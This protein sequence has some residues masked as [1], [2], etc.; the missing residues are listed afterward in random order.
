MIRN[1]FLLHILLMITANAES[2][3]VRGNAYSTSGR[4]VK[5]NSGFI[6]E[7]SD[8][9]LSIFFHADR[10]ADLDLALKVRVPSGESTLQATVAGKVWSASLHGVTSFA[11]AGVRV[12]A[13]GYVRVD[14][15][16]M[17]NAGAVIAEVTELVVTS[18][19]PGLTL[20][21][22]KD[23]E[24]NRFYWGRR[25]PSVHLSYAPPE[26][27]T[28]EWFYNEVTVPVGMDPVGSYFMANGFG[29]GYFGMQVNSATERR[30]LF[31]VWSPFHTDDPKNIPEDKR[32]V[33]LAKG[34]GVTIGEFGNEGSGGQS[35]FRHSW[36]AGE[37]YRFLNQA[38]PDGKGGTAYSAW[39]FVKE[40]AR[41]QLIAS[42]CRP[43]TDKHL[44]GLHSF[45]ENFMDEQGWITREASYGNQW[46]RDT[47]GQWH[48]LTT[49]RFTAD[50]IASRG[51]RLD[52][53][54]GVKEG[55]FFLRNGGFFFEP[56]KIGSKFSLDTVPQ[57]PPDIDLLQIESMLKTS[58]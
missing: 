22:V 33:M 31:S 50:D 47:D 3:P 18:A 42:F 57:A 54:G 24:A 27:K 35:F 51:Y 5:T 4:A 41:W 34:D 53:T 28:I 55:R 26:G 6:L 40:E 36:K 58:H 15:Q 37:T 25:G 17:H 20:S 38:R 2:I 46:A 7:N 56:V 23:N 12:D 9:V 44:T 52:F 43:A 49:A 32:V 29:E 8:T 13:P 39:F 16:G 48:R 30:I 19:T 45:L 21:H 1:I 10:A 11:L 14:L